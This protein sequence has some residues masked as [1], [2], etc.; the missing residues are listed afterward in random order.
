METIYKFF[1]MYA[2]WDFATAPVALNDYEA[3]LK[4][5]KENGL[6]FNMTNQFTS[7]S[8]ENKKDQV[9]VNINNYL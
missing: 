6:D 4:E 1:E 8:K 5:K 9:Q 3:S 7:W 2:Y